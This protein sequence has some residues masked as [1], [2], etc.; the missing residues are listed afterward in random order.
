MQCIECKTEKTLPKNRQPKGWKTLGTARYCDKCWKQRYVLYALTFPVVGPV[1]ASWDDLRE[2]LNKAWAAST[3]LANWTATELAKNDVIRKP[4]DKKMPAMPAIYLYGVAKEKFC[5]WQD[6]HKCYSSANCVMRYVEQKYRAARFKI[7]WTHDAALM[8]FRYPV[9]YPVHNDDWKATTI[10]QRPT[11]TFNLDGKKWTLRLKGGP[12]MARQLAGFRQIERGEAVK[13]ELAI[14][15]GA[16]G[17]GKGDHRNGV[18]ESGASRQ[19]SRVMV[20]LVAWFPRPAAKAADKTMLLR[21]DP[22]AFFVAE[23]ENRRPW[24]L[25]ADHIPRYQ[26]EH[27]VFLQRFSEDTKYEKRWPKEKR[28][29]MN[30][31]R[32]VRCRKNENRMDNWCDQATALVAQYAERQGV[33]EVIYDD[34]IRSYVPSFR[35]SSLKTKLATKLHAKGIT[36]I[37]RAEE[38][39]KTEEKTEEKEEA[40]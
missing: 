5:G 11:V 35:W 1:D 33:C 15:R 26:A 37:E 40:V 31:H 24:I 8:S 18:S 6:W 36:L 38:K 17:K 3:S 28:Q 30:A 10:E 23:I 9:P 16:A 27:H 4:N 19:Y 21:T 13:G 39:E 25:N 29:Q 7:V 12:E 2:A 14:Y 34:S 20:K 32:E 22:H